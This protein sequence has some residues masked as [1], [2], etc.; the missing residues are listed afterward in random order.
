ME[1]TLV[2]LRGLTDQ[3]PPRRR[4]YGRLVDRHPAQGRHARVA[5]ETRDD[6]NRGLELVRNEPSRPTPP[7]VT[8]AQVRVRSPRPELVSTRLT[9]GGGVSATGGKSLDDRARGVHQGHADEF[10]AD[11]S[12]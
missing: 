1:Q 12:R 8:L 3:S 5:H 6:G 11:P 4:D 9:L 10:E 7:V 2:V